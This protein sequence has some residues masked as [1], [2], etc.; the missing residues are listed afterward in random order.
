M[1]LRLTIAQTTNDVPV[2]EIINQN[3]VPISQMFHH[4]LHQELIPSYRN[5]RLW[6][7]QRTLGVYKW[8]TLGQQL[9]HHNN[10]DSLQSFYNKIY[11]S[12]IL[13]FAAVAHRFRITIGTYIEYMIS[14]HLNDGTIIKFKKCSVGLYYYDDTNM[15]NHTANNQ[16]TDYTFTNTVEIEKL[17]FHRHEIK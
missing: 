1:Q 16:V 10:N 15:K 13:S 9:H 17:Y 3:V 5:Q 6:L 7:R 4:Y 8:G 12:N 14:M 2:K 11:L